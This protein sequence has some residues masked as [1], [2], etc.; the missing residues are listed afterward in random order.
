M[1][2]IQLLFTILIISLSLIKSYAEK[3]EIAISQITSHP[4][5][6]KIRE[7]VLEGLKEKG[8][9]QNNANISFANAQGDISTSIQI[10]HKF[11]ANNPDVII[12]ISTQASQA[13]AQS[14]RDT[15]IPLI[16]CSV[17]NPVGAG[18]VT[19]MDKPGKNIS[20]TRSASPLKKLLEIINIVDPNI[21]Q[22]GVVLNYGEES[23]VNTLTELKKI[24]KSMDIKILNGEATNSGEVST[25]TESLV[26]KV[27]GFF[28]IQDNTVASGVAALM[29]VANREQ[30]PVYSVF[31][32]AAPLGAIISLTYDDYETGKEAGEMAATVLKGKII[33]DLPVRTPKVLNM[34]INKKQALALKVELPNEIVQQSK[35]LHH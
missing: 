33:G 15:N 31:I 21:K 18:L 27:D 20:G 3:P 14:I 9:T 12:A 19:S 2:L 29:Q 28:L 24:A 8:F 13:I 1:K 16:F 26:G 35:K 34:K 32:E 22:L 17:T 30:V 4:T 7:G 25:A 10:A 6:D 5:L 23:S 11:K